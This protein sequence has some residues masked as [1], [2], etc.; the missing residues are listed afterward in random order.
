MKTGI[1]R[2]LMFPIEVF[3]RLRFRVRTLL[4]RLILKKGD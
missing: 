2:V 3:T 4:Y 1:A